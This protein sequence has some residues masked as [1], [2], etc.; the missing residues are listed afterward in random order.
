[1]PVKHKFQSTKA[2]GP[3]SSLVRPSN[4]NDEHTPDLTDD[5]EAGS[6]LSGQRVVIVGTDGKLYYADCS[7]LSH[8]P[9]ILGITTGA[10]SPGSYP[11]IQT[12]GPMAEG[13]WSWDLGKFIFLSTNGQLTQTPPASG[14]LLVM[15][16]AVSAREMMIAIKEPISLS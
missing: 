16:W 3:D 4:W 8:L 7:N 11:S 6:A 9:R 13:T 2:D 1:M 14:F 15:G 5:Y 12:A 10:F